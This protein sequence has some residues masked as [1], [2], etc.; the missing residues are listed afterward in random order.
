MVSRYW[1]FRAL[2]A[3]ALQSRCT[4][5]RSIGIGIKAP[6]KRVIHRRTSKNVT[7]P[8]ICIIARAL[9]VTIAHAADNYISAVS[10]AAAAIVPPRY[11]TS[12]S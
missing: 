1:D 7:V 6:W 11:Q 5:V 2:L 12:A 3:L 8:G 4:S 9:A 10:R